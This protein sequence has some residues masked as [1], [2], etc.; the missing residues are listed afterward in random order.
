MKVVLQTFRN[1]ERVLNEINFSL[2]SLLKMTVIL[3]LISDFQG[4]HNTWMQVFG[5]D[6]P[7]QTTIT[8][9]FV[10]EHCLIQIK[11]GAGL[12]LP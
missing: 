9:E 4:M 2:E 12:D 7:V 8:S 10:D 1:L 11:G 5:S 3:K 6:D